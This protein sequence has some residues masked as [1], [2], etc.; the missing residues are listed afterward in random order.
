VSELVGCRYHAAG[1]AVSYRLGH[2]DYGRI[3]ERPRTPADQ[4]TIV[5]V[6]PRQPISALRHA[7][8]ISG[9]GCAIM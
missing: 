6:A 9:C 2:G 8:R 4:A 3:R 7:G 5:A 1:R